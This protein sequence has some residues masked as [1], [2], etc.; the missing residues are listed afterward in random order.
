MNTTPLKDFSG[1]D[2]DQ[3]LEKSERIISSVCVNWTQD[4]TF[5]YKLNKNK[6]DSIYVDTF[7]KALYGEHWG[8]RLSSLGNLSAKEKRKYFDGLMKYLVGSI[9]DISKS[10]TEYEKNYIHELVDYDIMPADLPQK[11]STMSASG[12]YL[13]QLHYHF[14]FPLKKRVFYEMIYICKNEAQGSAYIISLPVDPICFPEKGAIG[15]V[16]GRYTSIEKIRFDENENKL[17]WIMCTCSSA[18]GLIPQWLTNF[19]LNHAIAK[20]VPS[21][22]SWIDSI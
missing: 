3:L 18:G 22:L 5:K 15:N 16:V 1:L 7:H 21:I 17:T 6:E 19:S 9:G 11:S 2:P 10:H 13:V 12:G 8:A 20:D 14:Q 4:R